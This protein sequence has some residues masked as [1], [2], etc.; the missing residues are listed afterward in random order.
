MLQQ[1]GF[2]VVSL[3]DVAELKNN[4]ERNINEFSPFS[5]TILPGSSDWFVDSF[6]GQVYT[7][8]SMQSEGIYGTTAEMPD[9]PEDKLANFGYLRVPFRKIPRVIVNTLRNFSAIKADIT[10]PDFRKVA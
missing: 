9:Y 6:F 10:R 1:D 8:V 5:T 3:G 4:C 2:H 7:G